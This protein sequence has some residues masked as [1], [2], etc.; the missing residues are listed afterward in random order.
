MNVDADLDIY[1]LLQKFDK[2][3]VVLYIHLGDGEEGMF[4]YGGIFEDVAFAMSELMKQDENFCNVM[5]AAT[6]KYLDE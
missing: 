5:L 1:N 3:D 2:E 4:Y 6:N